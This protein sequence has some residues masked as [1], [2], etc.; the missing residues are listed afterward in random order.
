MV[1]IYL[2]FNI[3]P[4]SLI[5]NWCRMHKLNKP[6][7]KK[8]LFICIIFHW[9]SALFALN[10]KLGSF[11][12]FH[13]VQNW[14]WIFLKWGGKKDSNIWRFKNLFFHFRFKKFHWTQARP[15]IGMPT[16]RND[17]CVLTSWIRQCFYHPPT[18]NFVKRF[19]WKPQFKM[20]TLKR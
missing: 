15:R 5:S 4:I 3:L 18:E 16:N 20:M 13:Q 12:F 14:H 10:I 6:D 17:T 19:Y 11:F 7:A 1:H 8:S 9:H 2:R